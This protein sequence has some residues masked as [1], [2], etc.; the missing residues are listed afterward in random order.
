MTSGDT[1]RR[2]TDETLETEG[3]VG[4]SLLDVEDGAGG[5]G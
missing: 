3:E 1:A 5:F 2:L 4:G